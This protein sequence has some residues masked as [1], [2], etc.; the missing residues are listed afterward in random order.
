MYMCIPH[1]QGRQRDP[2]ARG[3]E[4]QVRV[5]PDGAYP[6]TAPIPAAPAVPAI[7]ASNSA[8]CPVL[9]NLGTVIQRGCGSVRMEVLV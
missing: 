5:S 3:Q 4:H 2:E 8:R 7:P 1:R 9:R 6:S